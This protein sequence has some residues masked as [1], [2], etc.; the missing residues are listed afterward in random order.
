MKVDA[1]LLNVW[2][3][4]KAEQLNLEVKD[5]SALKTATDLLGERKLKH[6]SSE[7]W[8]T[9]NKY[10][11]TNNRG[12]KN[13]PPKR[14]GE[15]KAPIPTYESLPSEVNVTSGMSTRLS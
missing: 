13:R 3:F 4:M 12:E 15:F 8:M 9:V 10:R 11:V 7:S 6:L 2:S 5:R 14:T 1:I